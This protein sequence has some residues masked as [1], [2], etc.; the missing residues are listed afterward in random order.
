MQRLVPSRRDLGIED[1]ARR[2]A[3]VA[4][5][6][7]GAPRHYNLP[8]APAS[9]HRAGAGVGNPVENGRHVRHLW[10]E[11]LAMTAIRNLFWPALVLAAMTFGCTPEESAP[12]TTN[13]TPPPGGNPAPK[14]TPAPSGSPAPSS[15]PSNKEMPDVTKPAPGDTK[16]A[17]KDD[18]PKLEPP[19]TDAP[20]SASADKLSSQEIAALKAFSP[21][22]QQLAIQQVL[23]PVSGDHLGAEEMTPV[24]VTAEGKT[25]FLC[26]ASCKKE[27]D[28]HPKEVIAKLAK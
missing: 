7:L 14:P 27:V 12:T 13:P 11:S 23:C 6:A 9:G 16:D 18:T 22:E 5:F 15:A 28:A 3:V 20:K 21:E 10:S 4:L 25:F 17:P 2:S 19:K 24:K 8:S 26:C 1:R